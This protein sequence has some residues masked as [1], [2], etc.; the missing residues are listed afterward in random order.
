M[1]KL[2]SFY[3]RILSLLLILFV[4][5]AC[6]STRLIDQWENPET[7]VYEA[8]KVL[9]IGM[10]ADA[11][12]RQSF[13][14]NLR[15]ALEKKGVTA[16]RSMDFFEQTFAGDNRTEAELDMIESSL[17]EAGFD[18]V[19]ISKI[20]GSE[21]KSSFA[22]V[23][24]NLSNDFGNFKEYYYTHQDVYVANKSET[25]KIYHTETSVFCICPGKEREL[26]WSG[27]IDVVDPYNTEGNVRDYVRTLLNTLEDAEL[28]IVP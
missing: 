2:F 11:Q 25:Y 28:V 15:S 5:I 13:E 23:Y 8:S 27:R 4:F 9:V 1:M 21:S 6:S 26:L 12:L 19:M 24:R 16:V 22:Q 18:V 3:L 7:P 20:T 17:L 14:E 10:S